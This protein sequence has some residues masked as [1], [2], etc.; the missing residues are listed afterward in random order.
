MPIPEGCTALRIDPGEKACAVKF[1][2]CAFDG[3]E[4]EIKEAYIPEGYWMDEW[5]YNRMFLLLVYKYTL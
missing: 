1:E 4:A 2:V 5:L 3:T